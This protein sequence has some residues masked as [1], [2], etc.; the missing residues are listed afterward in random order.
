MSTQRARILVFQPVFTP[1]AA[2]DFRMLGVQHWIVDQLGQVGLES[3]SAIFGEPGERVERL[4]ASEPP[5]DAWVRETLVQHDARLGLLLSFAVLGESLRLALARLVEARRGHPLRVLARWKLDESDDL[6]KSA[7]DVFLGVATRLGAEL[8]PH[9]W[10]DLF[11]TAD[12]AAASSFLT[13]VGCCAASDRGIVI[14]QSAMALRAALSAVAAGMPPALDLLPH[15]VA[16]L[17]ASGSVD[18]QT[19][20]TLGLATETA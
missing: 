9:A 6:P 2:F 5:R 8:R 12:V 3:M 19:L 20:A 7:H 15:L 14:D 16:S 18:E 17:R 11:G 1:G 4:C 10:S 13:A